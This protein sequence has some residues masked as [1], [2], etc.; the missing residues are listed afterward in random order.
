[1][2]NRH[3]VLTKLIF[4]ILSFKEEIRYIS[5][6]GYYVSWYHEE[7]LTKLGY[8][9]QSIIPAQ[10]LIQSLVYLRMLLNDQICQTKCLKRGALTLLRSL[11]YW[12]DSKVESIA[13]ED[14]VWKE[15]LVQKSSTYWPQIREV[16]YQLTILIKLEYI[17]Q[18]LVSK[19]RLKQ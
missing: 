13:L 3:A 17:W 1:M 18:C 10:S 8:T 9:A 6:L 14:M 19:H 11:K 16:A 2:K 5:L 7:R 4:L 12:I 15:S